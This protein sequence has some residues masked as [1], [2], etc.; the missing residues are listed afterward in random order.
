MNNYNKIDDYDGGNKLTDIDLL[1]QWLI[2]QLVT[3]NRGGENA[4][5]WE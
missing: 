2:S 4:E 1:I 3:C 5:A